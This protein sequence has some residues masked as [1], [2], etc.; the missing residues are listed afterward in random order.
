MTLD[1]LLDEDDDGTA[2]QGQSAAAAAAAAASMSATKDTQSTLPDASVGVENDDGSDA[3]SRGPATPTRT[4]VENAIDGANADAASTTALQD[5]RAYLTSALWTTGRRL[6]DLLQRA[7]ASAVEYYQQQYPVAPPASSSSASAAARSSDDPSMTPMATTSAPSV[8]IA[9]VASSTIASTSASAAT[10]VTSA[11]ASMTVATAV[12]PTGSNAPLAQAPAPVVQPSSTSSAA[13]ANGTPKL[14]KAAVVE[15]ERSKS[16]ASGIPLAQS[17]SAPSLAALATPNEKSLSNVASQS[18]AAASDTTT[19]A[20]ENQPPV[21]D[22]RQQQQQQESTPPTSMLMFPIDSNAAV[23]VELVDTTGAVRCGCAAP[24]HTKCVLDYTFRGVS[25]RRVAR[26]IFG[27]TVATGGSAQQ[28]IMDQAHA[29]R[30]H[31]GTS[32]LLSDEL[33]L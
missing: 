14:Q 6:N 22:Q 31:F 16:Q 32:V 21:A 12:G 30:E 4:P 29:R 18:A 9:E 19:P 25:V 2:S 3:E 23:P 10:G 8:G 28:S 17:S 11:A 13:A 27:S 20:A 24:L 15:H 7:Q 26:L 1:M 5:N 33:P